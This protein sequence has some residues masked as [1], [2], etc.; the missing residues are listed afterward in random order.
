MP[1][2]VDSPHAMIASDRV[3]GTDV[4]STTG[5]K[6]GSIDHLMI[7]K[8]SGQVTCAVLEFGG[9]LGWARSAIHCLGACSRTT[10][11]RKASLSRSTRRSSRARRDTAATTAGLG[12]RLRPQVNTH[13][14]V[15][16]SS[17]RSAAAG[18]RPGGA[19]RLRVAVG[20]CRRAA[21]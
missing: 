5:E 17:G 8:M 7:D 12:Q 20:S 4:Y 19:P 16:L 3:E 6:L 14:G 21:L 11:R 18:R 13:Y 9:F 15:P 2:T 10:P 1:G